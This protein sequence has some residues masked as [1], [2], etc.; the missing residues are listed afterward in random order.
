MSGREVGSPVAQDLVGRGVRAER[1]AHRDD[2]CCSHPNTRIGIFSVDWFQIETQFY[3]GDHWRENR[4]FRVT[5]CSEN[6]RF[7]RKRFP[8]QTSFGN[9]IFPKF[10][11]I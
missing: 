11:Q 1:P 3:F 10:F 9:R 2:R 7:S 8:K 6:G 5:K 4:D